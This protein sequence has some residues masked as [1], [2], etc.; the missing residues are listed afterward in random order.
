MCNQITNY[1]KI[2][3]KKLIIF[4]LSCFCFMSTY[5]SDDNKLEEKADEFTQKV[6]E[7][8]DVK[9]D[10]KAKVYDSQ[11]KYL[12]QIEE[13]NEQLKSGD[14]TENVAQKKKEELTQDFDKNMREILD[15]SPAV[16]KVFK[17]TLS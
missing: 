10:V 15:V 4:L 14:I 1:I 7:E 17:K 11:L 16:Y 3:M 5:A 12:K 2:D 13:V 6:Q 9:E 8:F